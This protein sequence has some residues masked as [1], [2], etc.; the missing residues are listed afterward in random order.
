LLAKLVAA[1]SLVPEDLVVLTAYPAQKA[2]LRQEINQ[3]KNVGVCDEKYL[4][5]VD[6]TTQTS[7]ANSVML[8]EDAV[9]EERS[10]A[11]VSATRA[12]TKLNELDSIGN[13]RAL[14]SLLT[15][16]RR[17]LVIVGD[18]QTLIADENWREWLIWAMANGII[19]NL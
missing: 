4:G 11:I 3:F 15:R 16:G 10:L 1:K 17:G 18:L 5:V 8:L 12:N 6:S 7:L 14:N 19:V 2:R 9:D 13:S